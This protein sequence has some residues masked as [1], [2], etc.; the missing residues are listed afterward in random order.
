LEVIVA[1]YFQ[2]GIVMQD[3]LEKKEQKLI[4]S[5]AIYPQILQVA[6]KD[7]Y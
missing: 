7:F 6:R 2:G 5:L 3:L 4:D 1:F